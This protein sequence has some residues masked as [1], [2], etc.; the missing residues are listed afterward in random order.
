MAPANPGDGPRLLKLH[1]GL[2]LSASHQKTK[3]LNFFGKSFNFPRKRNA[4]APPSARARSTKGVYSGI[5]LVGSFWRGGS[6]S[7]ARAALIMDSSIPY[8][9]RA[10]GATQ[11]TSSWCRVSGFWGGGEGV[12]GHRGLLRFGGLRV[13]RVAP[14]QALVEEVIG[15]RLAGFDDEDALG[16][17]RGEHG[18]GVHVHRDPGQR[19]D[20]GNLGFGILVGGLDLDDGTRGETALEVNTALF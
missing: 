14:L 12:L 15:R 9:L 17:Q 7:T 11:L 1:L 10:S 18:Q 5:Y 6:F 20:V 2:G 3:Q 19:E 8:Q 16:R 13:R 4:C